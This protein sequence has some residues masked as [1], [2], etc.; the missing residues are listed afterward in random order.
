MFKIYNVHYSACTA[1]RMDAIGNTAAG[2]GMQRHVFPA[3]SFIAGCDY[4][5][6]GGF[7]TLNSQTTP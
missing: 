7:I 2:E 5:I 3:A 4:P 6:D 1:R